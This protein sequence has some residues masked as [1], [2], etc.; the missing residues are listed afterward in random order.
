MI[1]QAEEGVIDKH[2]QQ[3]FYTFEKNGADMSSAVDSIWFK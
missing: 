1:T 2:I 3:N